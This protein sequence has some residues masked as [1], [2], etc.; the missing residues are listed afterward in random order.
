[1]L[2]ARA[3]QAEPRAVR[4]GRTRA[5]DLQSRL[6]KAIVS[7]VYLPGARL[8]EQSLADRFGVSRT[9]VREAL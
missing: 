8:D 4:D 3:R 5:E 6:A 2:A 7:G 1:M 9:P